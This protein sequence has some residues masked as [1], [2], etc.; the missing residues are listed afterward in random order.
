MDQE[1]WRGWALVFCGVALTGLAGCGGGGG[2]TGIA[3]LGSSTSDAAAV[4][5][6][7]STGTTGAADGT[8]GT[9]TTTGTPA[10]PAAA[11]PSE[12]APASPTSAPILGDCEMF[13]STAIFNTR[14]DDTSRFPAH[15]KTQEWI[16]LVGRSVPFATDWGIDV[17]PANYAVYYGMPINIVDGTSATTEWP[18]VSFDFAT[19]GVFWDRGYPDKSDCAVSDGNGGFRIGRSCGAIDPGQRRFP[20][21]LASRIVNED[22]HC[23]DPRTCGDR[24]V[25]VVEK[26]ACRLWESFFSYNLSGQ[27]YTM[28]AAAWDLKSLALRPDDWASGDAAGLPITPLLAKA[29]EANSG[30]I[31]HALRVN[32]SDA[33]LS[34]EHVWP[35]RFGAGGENPGAIPFGSL[36][37]LRADFVIPGEWTPQAKALATAAKRYGL[38]VSDNGADFHVQGEPNAAWD[39]RTNA[40][41]RS[42][43]MADMEFVDLKAVT[44]DPRFSRDSMAAR[45]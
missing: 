4:G 26:G 3:G 18:V 33:K 44:G 21:P 24:H 1:R 12:A 25:L 8:G 27:W 31:R 16:N 38:Y 43:T 22:G 9:D 6:T 5:G 34:T 28:A 17:D 11:P 15:P 41:M 42:I 37:R 14:I 30:E 35:A 19:S 20:F 32:F 23:N 2:G 39:L 45:W 10:A 29:A 40:Q 36:L 13:P 7:G